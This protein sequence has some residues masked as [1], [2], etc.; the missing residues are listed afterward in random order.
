MIRVT[1]RTRPGPVDL[2]ITAEVS[3]DGRSLGIV[4]WRHCRLLGAI[5]AVAAL[6]D[7]M[8][9]RARDPH[10]AARVLLRAASR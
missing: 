9:V 7:G 4:R 3:R 8:V 6:P 10:V 2:H 1:L 5:G